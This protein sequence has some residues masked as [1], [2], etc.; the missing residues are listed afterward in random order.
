MSDTTTEP[1]AS[2]DPGLPDR[3]LAAL[4]T[5]DAV[6]AEMPDEPATYMAFVRTLR[7]AGHP[8][9]AEL[10][11]GEAARRFPADAELAADLARAAEQRKDWATAL[12]RWQQM[13]A[14]F[15]QNPAGHL[16]TAA[17]LRGE[18]G[19]SAEAEAVLEE[20]AARFPN[21]SEVWTEYAAAAAERKDRPAAILRY[22]TI[23]ERFPALPGSWRRLV[24][25]LRDERRFDEADMVAAEALVRF[26]EDRALL[27]EWA[28]VAHYR[29]DWEEAARRWSA[30]R[31]A[32]PEA[33]GAY[34]MHGSV[35]L[36][37]LNRLDESDEVLAEGVERFAD[38]ADM[39]MDYARVAEARGDMAEAQRRWD[40][41]KMRFPGNAAIASNAARAAAALTPA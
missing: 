20:A 14:A 31:L 5:W 29:A 4:L 21:R 2:A 36:H 9:Q 37:H 34:W 17:M 11:L 19:R 35:L 27:M 32:Q 25:L 1:A 23:R 15:P 40:A 26:P 8:Q 18:L 38:H 10:V 6:R 33:K 16:R 13:R 12:A 24:T 3:W 22:Q 7:K 28:W 39:A 41:A 30:V